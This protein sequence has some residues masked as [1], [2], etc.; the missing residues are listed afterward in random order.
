MK[1]FFLLLLSLIAGLN[2][3]ALNSITDT[4]LNG[5]KEAVKAPNFS[6]QGEGV[7]VAVIDT[8]VDY[9]NQSLRSSLF[10]GSTDYNNQGR[11]GYGYDFSNGST[12]PID[13]QGHGT[14]VAGI[15]Q[16][17]A[18]KAKIL[19]LR[20]FDNNGNTD[21]YKIVSAIRFAMLM[22]A[23]VINLSL[24]GL[25]LDQ[26]NQDFF[27]RLVGNATFGNRVSIVTAAGNDYHKDL[28]QLPY[29]PANINSPKLITVCSV[30][31]AGNLSDFSNIGKNSV[32][33][34]A[35]GED[36]YSYGINGQ[37]LRM[38][39]G[40]SMAAPYV[41]GALALMLS[42]DLSQS[43]ELLKSRLLQAVD[44]QL[45]LFPFNQ[46]GGKLNIKAAL[47]LARK[48]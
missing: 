2:A 21:R 38:E 13:I 8:G 6:K 42:E 20:V 32:D 25:E 34:C 11:L 45:N 7:L 18:P 1:L 22:G 46:T 33:L 35:L 48:K 24:G 40:T 15:I 4:I 10:F 31:R 37:A 44:K 30:D 47:D 19:A 5:Q 27:N 23:R 43:P 29:F 3:F 14:H 17:I 9:N 41:A 28:D 26:V 36:V 39:S 16:S 12:Y